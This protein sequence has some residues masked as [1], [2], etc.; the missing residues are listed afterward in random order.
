MTSAREG[1]GATWTMAAPLSTR[2]PT[3]SRPLFAEAHS[4][5]P[6]GSDG[7]AYAMYSP[8]DASATDENSA[9]ETSPD[10]PDGVRNELPLSGEVYTFV[11]FPVASSS[12]VETLHTTIISGWLPP[13]HS[14]VRPPRRSSE[15]LLPPPPCSCAE[16]P[17]VQSEL[18]AVWRRIT[19][20][21]SPPRSRRS[22]LAH[23]SR[24]PSPPLNTDSLAATVHLRRP[25]LVPAATERV[26]GLLEAVDSAAG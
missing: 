26:A 10:T 22:R 16:L 12:A 15:C 25:T 2:S 18:P 1:C 9:S 19:D 7:I 3:Q 6:P 5:T 14:I 4:T 11:A 13:A 17:N 24:H 23:A 20:G 8:V 21:R